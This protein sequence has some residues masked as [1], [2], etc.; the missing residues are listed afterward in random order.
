MVALAVARRLGGCE[1]TPRDPLCAEQSSTSRASRACWQSIHRTLEPFPK[2]PKRP[3][4]LVCVCECTLAGLDAARRAPKPRRRGPRGRAG[5]RPRAGLAAGLAA[6]RAG[7]RANERALRRG[8]HGVGRG[9]AVGAGARHGLARVLRDVLLVEE[10]EGLVGPR[11][12]RHAVGQ[13]RVLQG[14]GHAGR[15]QGAGPVVAV[16]EV[17]VSAAGG[18]GRRA[19]VLGQLLVEATGPRRVRGPV[20]RRGGGGRQA[21][22]QG[23]AGYDDGQLRAEGRGRV[24][25]GM[26]SRKEGAEQN[27]SGR[28]AGAEHCVV[29]GRVRQPC[30]A[31]ATAAREGWVQVA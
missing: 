4:F 27:K 23:E 31:N 19:A 30:H 16:A 20:L 21:R 6:G 13:L 9:V 3:N 1:A 24:R 12:A 25:R 18:A 10:P 14:V 17:R 8:A 22:R 29:H 26:A 15:G 2:A 5:R 11:P 28:S 7:R